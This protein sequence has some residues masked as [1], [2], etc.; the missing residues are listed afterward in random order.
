MLR[1]ASHQRTSGTSTVVVAAQSKSM[2]SEG[3]E[4]GEEVGCIVQRGF[5]SDTAGGVSQCPRALAGRRR[6]KAHEAHTLHR[7]HYT[8]THGKHLQRGGHFFH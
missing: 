4:E 8:R 1:P 6:G 2:H 7:P 3:V 5:V